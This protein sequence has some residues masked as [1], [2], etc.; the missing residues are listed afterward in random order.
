MTHIHGAYVDELADMPPVI[1]PDG[2]VSV[3]AQDRAEPFRVAVAQISTAARALGEAWALI[4]ADMVADTRAWTGAHRAAGLADQP[5][6]DPRARAL[7]L[8]QHRNT[9]PVRRSHARRVAR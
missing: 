7:W 1:G 5:P 2:T 8:R 6:D 4:T 3:T 9:C